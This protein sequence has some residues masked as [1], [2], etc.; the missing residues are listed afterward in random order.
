MKVLDQRVTD[1]YAIYHGDC[2]EVMKGVPSES[3]D[4]SIYSPPFRR[5]V[6]PIFKRPFGPLE[7]QRL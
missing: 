5:N 6:I 3:I 7:L 4:L 2:I 1:R